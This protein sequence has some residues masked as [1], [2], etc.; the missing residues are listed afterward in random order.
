VLIVHRFLEGMLTNYGAV[1]PTP[2]VQVVV[3]MDG[4]GAPH[5]KADKYQTYVRDQAIQ[6]GGVKLFYKHDAPLWS[7]AEVLRLDPAPDVV[8]Y[9]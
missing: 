9:Q 1:H 7:P 3:D 5:V 2:S 4:F 6:Y 8:I